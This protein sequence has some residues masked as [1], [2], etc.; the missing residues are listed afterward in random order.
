MRT[1]AR[2]PEITDAVIVTEPENIGAMRALAAENMPETVVSVIAGG[3]T[4]QASVKCGLDALPQ[5]CGA[6]LIHDG[7]RPLVH[8]SDVRSGMVEVR[9]G[10]G[11]LLAAPV[12]DTVKVGNP[13]T[14]AVM[15][16]LERETLWAAQTPQFAM[17]NEMRRAHAD[18]N[19]HGVVATDDVALLERLGL[20]VVLVPSSSENFKVTVP[21]DLA[22][23]E[24]LL[25]SRAEHV[26]LEEMIL[27]VEVFAES[28]LAD[29]ICTELESRGAT[30]DA[31][32]RDLPQG[33]AVRAFVPAE[34]LRGFGERFEAFAVGKAMFTARFS[35]YVGGG[36]HAGNV[37]A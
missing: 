7:A 4:R 2:L 11:A 19:K 14:M 13:V 33:I 15:R 30:I 6:V 32:D 35:H 3:E 12:T 16:T 36:E 31:V 34:G 29:A 28:L 9:A 25:Q 5:R 37:H 23:A 26:P 8:A 22:R 21:R 17:V 1:F 18:A 10:R 24:V 20:E 27:L